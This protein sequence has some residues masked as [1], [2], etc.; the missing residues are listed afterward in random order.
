[1]AK[2]VNEL[3]KALKEVD[4][5]AASVAYHGP[6]FASARI[7]SDLQQV[8]PSWTGSFS[9]SWQI[10]TPTHKTFKCRNF[11]GQG[12]PTGV[13]F[14]TTTGRE[15]IKG[16]FSLNSVVFEIENDSPYKETAFDFE[17]DMYLPPTPEPKFISE[18]Y[19]PS[20]KWEVGSGSR[21][22]PKLRGS[23]NT[24]S[25]GR[26]SRTA[27][28]NWFRKYVKAGELD[29]AIRIEMDRALKKSDRRTATRGFG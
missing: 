17:K 9:N 26:P 28:L 4:R 12:A 27:K 20:S 7:I 5:V 29:R 15:A 6:A 11:R 24:G 14:P 25:G 1:M 21:L 8:G 13:R 3:W 23:I 2:F 22:T 16:I 19:F 18:G 10:T